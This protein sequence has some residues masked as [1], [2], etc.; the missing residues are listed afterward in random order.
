MDYSANYLDANRFPNLDGI[1]AKIITHLIKSESH[2]AK[3]LWR[4]VKYTTPDALSRPELTSEEKRALVFDGTNGQ[5]SA[6]REARV[7][8]AP[9]VDDAWQEQ[10]SSLYI[11][12]SG[13]RPLDRLHAEVVVNIEVVVHSQISVVIGNGDPDLN[14]DANPNDSDKEG[15]IVV[16]V[17]NR[18]TA[19]VK[20]VVAELNGIYLDGVGYL[21]L[22]PLKEAKGKVDSKLWN[23]RSFYGH[24]ISMVMGISGVSDSPMTGF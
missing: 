12:V 8:M 6:T 19:L 14:P 20:D 1:E 22:E 15:N 18:A 9:F 2:Y 16:A 7:F 10:C 17:K 13:V 3:D 24:T 4:L 11:Y 23:V 5:P 21:F